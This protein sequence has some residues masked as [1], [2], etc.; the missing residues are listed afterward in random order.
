[1]VQSEKGKLII[2]LSNVEIAKKLKT[3]LTQ[4]GFDIIALCTSGNELIRLVMQYS[5]DLVLVGYKFKDMSLLDVYETLV[6]LTSFLAIV[7][8]PYRSFIEEDTDIYC[9]GTKISNVLLTNAIDLIFQSKRRIK[10]LKEQ[11]EKL[12]HTLEDRKLIEKAKGQLMATSG[13]TEN[14]AFRYM[15]KISMDS[16]KRMKDIA[17]LILSE[18]Q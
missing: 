8:E 11:V 15:Q 6:D 5:P 7:N 1:M 18:I 4:E 14:E 13:L 3:L 2:A 9:I 16:G 12:E 17:S 10:K